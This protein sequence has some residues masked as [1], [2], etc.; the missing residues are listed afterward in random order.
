MKQC[1]KDHD[2]CWTKWNTFS[3]WLVLKE[4][5]EV[6]E[7]TWDLFFTLKKNYVDEEVIINKQ[8]QIINAQ[9]WEASLTL[10]ASELDLPPDLYYYDIEYTFSWTVYT[11][12]KGKF[13]I[14]YKV[15]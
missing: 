15:R 7:I 13:Q 8:L 6:K 3:T 14:T 9:E 4:D 10:D 5:G 12:I 11:L 1:Q 2:I